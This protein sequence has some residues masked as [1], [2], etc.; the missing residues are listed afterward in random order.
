VAGGETR[1]LEDMAGRAVMVVRAALMVEEAA[2]MGVAVMDTEGT[3]LLDEA[4]A[5]GEASIE[6]T[7]KSVVVCTALSDLLKMS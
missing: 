2:V 1:M 5:Q 6:G 4:E 7:E 3:A